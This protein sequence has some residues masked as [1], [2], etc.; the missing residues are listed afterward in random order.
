MM[1]R[2]MCTPAALSEFSGGDTLVL[3]AHHDRITE[4]LGRNETGRA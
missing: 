1:A 3:F 2:P 4:I